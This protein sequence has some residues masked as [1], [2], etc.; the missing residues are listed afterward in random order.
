MPTYTC[1]RPFV[2]P[3]SSV[4]FRDREV[5]R[6]AARASLEKLGASLIEL[7]GQAFTSVVPVWHY[8]APMWMHWLGDGFDEAIRELPS[9]EP[10]AKVHRSNDLLQRRKVNLHI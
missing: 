7:K 2:A 6:L 1:T 3:T 10:A 4:A 5:A 9:A 8:T